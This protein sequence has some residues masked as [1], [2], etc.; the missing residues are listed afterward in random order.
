MPFQPGTPRR[1]H[2]PR[3]PS[4]HHQPTPVDSP[5]SYE[6]DGSALLYTPQQ[7]ATLLQ[8]RESWLRKKAAARTIPCT[9]LGKHLRFS[10]ADLAAIVAAAAQPPVGRRP[11]RPRSI[12]RDPD[13]TRGRIRSV[14]PPDRNDHNHTD[15][16]SSWP[17]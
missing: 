11:R 5:G 4:E 7:A 16:S 8:V 12:P 3:P 9:F 15:G 14:H 6:Q 17:R 10:P 13:L 2:R 1:S